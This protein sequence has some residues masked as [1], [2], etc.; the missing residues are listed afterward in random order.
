MVLIF[1]RLYLGKETVSSRLDYKDGHELKLEKV[2]PTFAS[3]NA[4]PPKVTRQNYYGGINVMLG[5]RDEICSIFSSLFYR[6]LFVCK[7]IR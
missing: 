5:L 3:L 4:I 1:L 2:G 7:G 6:A